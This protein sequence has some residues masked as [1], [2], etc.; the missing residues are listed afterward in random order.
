MERKKRL[1][2]TKRKASAILNAAS[3]H[4][5]SARSNA[6]R[7][8]GGVALAAGVLW[9]VFAAV[10]LI[11]KK[12]PPPTKTVRGQV[13]DGS[14]GGITGAA[15]EMTDLTTGKKTAIY[16]QDGGRFLF[17]DLRPTHDYQFQAT[18]QGKQSEIRKVSSLD[19]RLRMVVNLHI[20]PPKE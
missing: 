20:P 6:R 1:G 19:V 11:A 5:L 10:P 17:A 14:G 4:E 16:T 13:L 18:Y 15:V 9:L 7:V 2:E 8:A 12:S 3:H